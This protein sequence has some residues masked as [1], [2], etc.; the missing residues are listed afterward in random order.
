MGKRKFLNSQILDKKDIK[1]Q[2]A[3]NLKLTNKPLTVSWSTQ[4]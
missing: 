3:C 4:E 1:Y 2:T